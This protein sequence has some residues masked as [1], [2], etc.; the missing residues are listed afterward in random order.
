MSYSHIESQQTKIDL[1]LQ[2]K[3]IYFVR[4]ITSIGEAQTMKIVKN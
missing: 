2:P 3:G 1:S 4:V